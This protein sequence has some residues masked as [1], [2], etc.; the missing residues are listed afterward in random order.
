MKNLSFS[1]AVKRTIAGLSALAMLASAGSCA[2][3]PGG[4]SGEKDPD[5]NGSSSAA[6]GNEVE[7]IKQAGS[8]YTYVAEDIPGT[9]EFSY[10]QSICAFPSSDKLLITAYKD[11]STVMYVTDPAFSDIKEISY[12]ADDA[13]NIQ[14]YWN[15]V[16]GHDGNIYIVSNITDFGD[17]KLPDL[18]DP[19]FDGENFDYEELYKD[20]VYRKKLAVLSEDG[21]IISENEITGLEKYAYDDNSP[22]SIGNIFPCGDGSVIANVSGEEEI[23]LIINADGTVGD[24]LDMGDNTW[25]S[26]TGYDSDGNIIGLTWGEEGQVVKTIN[27]ADMKPSGEDLKLSGVELNGGNAIARGTGDYRFYV[28]GSTALYGVK[29]D[30]ST[31]QIVNWVDSDMDGSSVRGF[32]AAE[33]GTFIVYSEDYINNTNG[34]MRLSKSDG[35]EASKEIITLA[36]YGSDPYTT[37]MV[38][39][40]NKANDKYRIKV[41]DYGKYYEYDEE[42][43]KM[44]NSPDNQLKMDIVAGKAPDMVQTSANLIASLANKGAFADLY[45]YLG[46]DGTVKKEELVDN[47]IDACEVNGK[48]LSIVPSF[49]VSTLCCKKKFYDKD[50]WNIDEFIDTVNNLPEGMSLFNS[51]NTKLA[52]FST[53]CNNGMDFVDLVAGTC[54]FDSPEFV[55]ILEFCNT[56]PDEEGFDWENATDEEQSKYWEDRQAAVLN[57]KAL[58]SNMYLYDIRQYAQNRYGYVGDDMTIVGYPTQDG[59]IARVDVSSG[60]AILNSSENKDACWQFISSFFTEEY[61]TGS[62]IYSLPALKSAFE[63]KLDDAMKD[64]YWEDADGKKQTYKD[65]VYINGETKEIPNLSKEERDL[66]EKYILSA[67]GGK[68]FIYNDELYNIINEEVNSFFSG[69]RS[70]QETA[71]LIQ[72]RLSILVSEQS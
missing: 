54:S 22:A 14:A 61:Q 10:L 69:Y 24:E 33:D 15:A 3:A 46:K 30:G 57:D 45:D 55:K 60:Y 44:I 62:T 58:L 5:S 21:E 70:A 40:F 25:F 66:V 34:F 11:D 56:F 53:L 63:K 18:S 32:V 7:Q 72:N 67:G 29:A 26:A 59:S 71:D 52:V 2:A 65:S 20:V 12:K 68:S 13:E 41:V 6:A 35:T 36:L 51:D 43:E 37:K 38:T 9:P 50:S 28:S 19:D 48:L 39:D 1:N 23:Y 31:Q 49:G 4:S 42:N 47:V 17:K 64:P 27:V 8:D 16:P